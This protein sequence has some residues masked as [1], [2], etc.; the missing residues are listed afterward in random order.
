MGSISGKFGLGYGNICLLDSFKVRTLEEM[1]LFLAK[2]TGT[3][4]KELLLDHNIN[5]RG[6]GIPI[7]FIFSRPI[8]SVLHIKR[9]DK[10]VR[11][12]RPSHECDRQANDSFQQI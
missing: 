2:N 9:P 6:E 3:S 4:G 1:M 12:P 10:I 11:K 5:L 7:I 8:F